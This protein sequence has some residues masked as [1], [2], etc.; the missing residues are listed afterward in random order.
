[1]PAM[2][3]V[4]EDVALV[5]CPNARAA[6]GKQSARDS[7][8]DAHPTAT[9]AQRVTCKNA[10]AGRNTL[11]IE[12]CTF[13]SF[14]RSLSARIIA[15]FGLFEAD[16]RSLHRRR[17]DAP[18]E[19]CLRNPTSSRL[20]TAAVIPAGIV[21][22]IQDCLLH[23]ASTFAAIDRGLADDKPAAPA[24]IKI[25]HNLPYREGSSKQWRLDPGDAAGQTA[26]CDRGHSRRRLAEGDKSSF[27]S[28]QYG[29]PGNIEDFA[30][31]GFVA[32]T[33]NYRL[34]DE[35]P[36]PAALEDCKCTVRWLRAHAHDYN[37]DPKQIGAYGNSA[38]A[39]WRCC[40]D[41]RHGGGLEGDGPHQTDRA[42][43]R[44]PVSDSGPIDLPFQL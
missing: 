13:T 26:P 21:H 11:N 34:S 28:R 19:R 23:L 42:S 15:I 6:R 41:D 18:L 31:L 14:W 40:W 20:R 9:S 27:A 16:V 10:A 7:P 32:V 2:T 8:P 35:A 1:M 17:V 36:F 30:A 43:C 38:A 12:D 44:Q 24:D 3:S 37:L 33:I 22:A 25:L 29:V 39:I 4:P 5:P